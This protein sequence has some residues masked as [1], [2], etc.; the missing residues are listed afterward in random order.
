MR[1]SVFSGQANFK[2]SKFPDDSGLPGKTPGASV[3]VDALKN[4]ICPPR[5]ATVCALRIQSHVRVCR[6]CRDRR[7]VMMRSS[8][9]KQQNLLCTGAEL[10]EGACLEQSLLPSAARGSLGGLCSP[11]RCSSASALG[12]A[13]TAAASRLFPTAWSQSPRPS[14][15]SQK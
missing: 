6:S 12:A 13:G 4:L 3:C 11:P 10:G 9:W 7:R 2:K 15:S 5:P 8:R 14:N 1:T